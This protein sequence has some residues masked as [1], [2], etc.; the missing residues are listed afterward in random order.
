MIKNQINSIFII[1]LSKHIDQYFKKYFFSSGLDDKTYYEIKKD[2]G[3]PDGTFFEAPEV[4]ASIA[5]FKSI[6]K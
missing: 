5:N 6:N 4:N 3:L 1:L 2:I